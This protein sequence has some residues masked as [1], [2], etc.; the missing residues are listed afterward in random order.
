[1]TIPFPAQ[2]LRNTYKFILQSDK[3]D[4][5][6]VLF[7]KYKPLQERIVGNHLSAPDLTQIGH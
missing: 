3:L 1:M 4:K 2:A 5:I 7:C 6:L